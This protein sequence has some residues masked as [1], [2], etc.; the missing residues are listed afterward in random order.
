MVTPA[1]RTRIE[2]PD[3]AT[4]LSPEITR[5]LRLAII[6]IKKRNDVR[7]IPVIVARVYFRKSFMV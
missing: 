4:G 6:I 2:F 1:F 3:I 5:V 7:I